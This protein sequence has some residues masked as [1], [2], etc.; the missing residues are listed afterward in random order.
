MTVNKKL[1][2]DGVGQRTAKVKVSTPSAARMVPD[3]FACSSSR[4]LSRDSTRGMRMPYRSKAE[5][6]VCRKIGS[7]RNTSA[8][9]HPSDSTHQRCSFTS[10]LLSP[11]STSGSDCFALSALAS[12]AAAQDAAAGPSHIPMG[13]SIT[14]SLRLVVE[15]RRPGTHWRDEPEAQRAAAN[16]RAIAMHARVERGA[17]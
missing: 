12:C 4:G 6:R 7:G 8:M 1:T 14:C 5:S 3:A 16:L 9:T 11:A 17:S 2:A 13:S 10:R 15:G